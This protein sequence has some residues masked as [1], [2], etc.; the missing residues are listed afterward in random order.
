MHIPT[1]THNPKNT[2]PHAT[3][4][5][6]W[7]LLAAYFFGATP[8]WLIPT[9]V[10]LILAQGGA[11]PVLIGAFATVQFCAV[12]LAAPLMPYL[13]RYLNP[14]GALLAGS[15]LTALIAAG[16]TLTDSAMAWMLFGAVW[17]LLSGV[18]WIA[19][20]SLVAELAPPA[21]RGTFI[22]AFETMLG[23]AALVGPSIL[24]LTGTGTA[25]PFVLAVGL[26]LLESALLLQM[27][28]PATLH[29]AHPQA[30]AQGT[31]MLPVLRAIPAV[32]LA[33]LI[34]GIFEAGTF[35]I[36][37]V[38]GLALGLGALLAT[39][40]V[41][42]IGVGSFLLQ[43]PL[44]LLADRYDVHGIFVGSISLMLLGAVL[45]PLFGGA[46]PL[47]WALA[48][49]W[50]GVGGGLYTL[51]MVQIGQ[52]F[53]GASLLRATSLLVVIY[54]V[55][56]AIGPLLGGIALDISPRFGLP[57]LFAVIGAGGLAALLRVGRPADPVV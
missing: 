20:E 39:S 22:G 25:L 40:L 13:S 55:G 23:A 19:G 50:G 15:L 34:G 16:Y 28:L 5:A 33:A 56:S 2:N 17:G 57:L 30:E 42:A 52:R 29:L 8:S 41:T 31:G 1:V 14:K 51:A 11:S 27:R 54:T 37:P 12:L 49:V 43:Y 10:T 38:Y 18:R 44:G 32:L 3:P 7:Y 53:R 9:A 4:R 24:L 45:L 47:L 36:L 6:I 26:L 35:A 21:R 48:F 46:G